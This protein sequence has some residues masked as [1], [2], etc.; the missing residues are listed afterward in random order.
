MAAMRW[1]LIC[2]LVLG[3]AWLGVA[4]T[5]PVWAT[6]LIWAML[7]LALWSLARTG[8]RDRLWQQSPVALYAGWLT[9]ASCVGSGI[10][11]AGY[12]MASP[13]TA[14]LIFLTLGLAIA[15]VVA[16]TLTRAPEYAAGVIWALAGV[17]AA[18]LGPANLPVL[19]LAGA[20]ILALAGTAWV[21]RAG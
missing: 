2:S 14:A 4:Q 9:A 13:Q 21:R 15:V 20:G 16:L 3:A 18:N 5:A 17:I 8:R 11:V 6:A 7:G 19:L 1:P 10:V 12:G